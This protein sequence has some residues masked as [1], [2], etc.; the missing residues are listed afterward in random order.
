MRLVRP[1]Q[2][3]HPLGRFPAC[4]LRLDTL[5]A[6]RVDCGSARHSTCALIALHDLGRPADLMHACMDASRLH[7]GMSS[8]RSAPRL[9]ASPCTSTPSRIARRWA[10]WSSKVRAAEGPLL[11]LWVT[12]SSI[13]RADAHARAALH[14]TGFSLPGTVEAKYKKADRRYAIKWVQWSPLHGTTLHVRAPPAAAA[15]SSY[16]REHAA[17]CMCLCLWQ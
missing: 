4:S 15:C 14:A 11:Q 5:D 12:A 2:E 9:P 17:D 1:R 3:Q 6:A 10:M 13:A 8:C 7:A 16:L